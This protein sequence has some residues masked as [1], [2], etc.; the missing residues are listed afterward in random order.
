MAIFRISNLAGQGID[1]RYAAFGLSYQG[2]S[3]FAV[4][5][6]YDPISG[7]GTAIFGVSNNPVVNQYD[8]HYQQLGV[9]WF[10][11]DEFRGGRSGVNVF[12]ASNLNLVGTSSAV[13]SLNVSYDEMT[14]ANDEFYGNDYADNI[15]AWTGNDIIFGNGGDDNIAGSNGNDYIDGGWGI[16]TATFFGNISNYVFSRNPDGS[17][18]VTDLTGLIGSDT[19]TNVE[20]FQFSDRLL[21]FSDLFPVAPP[22]PPTPAE[23][24][25][26]E[27]VYAGNNTLYG[28]SGSNTL[29][30][31][32]GNDKLYGQGGN[33][34]LYGGTGNDALYGGTGKDAF[35]F[36][37]KA[38]KATNK[39][40][41]KDFRV[42]D[43]TVRLDNAVFTKVGA[44]GT[45]KTSAFWTNTTGKAH[46]RS[47]RII[48]DKDS[49]VLY[50][51]ADG[52]GKGAA[53]AFATI[54]KNL[55]MTNKDFYVI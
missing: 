3:T 6:Q 52:S 41:I 50:Y 32:G 2:E 22:L 18:Q 29:K 44:N 46:D 12:Q 4:D 47:D 25:T 55:A 14:E 1:M 16:D 49:G 30:G 13:I 42:I 39:D 31:Y 34:Y 35:V 7:Y 10:R 40:A 27:E 21:S 24:A 36:N 45:L 15:F 23:P 17:V 51:D 33:D 9:D 53:T 48:Y 5:D 38:N 26:P 43:D 11:V 28:T 8:I 20:W 19:V 37:T 54:S